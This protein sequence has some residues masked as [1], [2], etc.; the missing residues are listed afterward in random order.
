MKYSR[1]LLWVLF[2]LLLTSCAARADQLIDLDALSPL[3]P[4]ASDREQQLRIAIAAVISPQGT[5][6]S[7][8]PL[9]NYLETKL[10]Y[11]VKRVQGS[12]YAETN[13]ILQSGLADL[14]FVCTGAYIEGSKE[15]GM[16]ILVVPEIDRDSVYYSWVIVP[17]NSTVE[18]FDDLQGAVF[19]FADPLSL[20]GWMYPNQLL[21][22]MNKMP[23]T[24]FSRTFFTYSHDKS[25]Q[26]VADGYADGAAVDSLILN[27]SI[28]RHPT[29]SDRLRI[30]H[31]SPPFGMPPVVVSPTISPELRTVLQKILL[32]MVYDDDGVAA[33]SS[34][35]IDRFILGDD[36]LYNSAREIQ[37]LIATEKTQTP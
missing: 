17:A 12:T 9:I 5:L 36:S 11:P 33:L 29:L 14:A 26:A 31:R 10:G 32:E 20:T 13:Q 37:G 24:F 16:Q 23:E 15:F 4:V 34:L 6:E 35:G 30:I 28:A 7:Y 21:R 1:Y 25:I 19:A 22:Q 3:P 8:T 27:Y 18:K 2:S